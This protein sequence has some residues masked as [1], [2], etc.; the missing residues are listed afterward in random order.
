MEV[1]SSYS[2]RGDGPDNEDAY[3]YRDNIFW[4][5]DGATDLYHLNLFGCDD[6]VARYVRQ[7]N[8]CIYDNANGKDRL[9]DIL[10]KSVSD[11][12]KLL[13]LKT[14]DYEIYKLPSF[15]VL[16]ARM[17]GSKCEYYILGDCVLLV[18]NKGEIIKLTD[19]RLLVFTEKNRSGIEALKKSGKLTYENK[20]ELLRDTRKYMNTENGYWIGSVDCAGIDNAIQGEIDIDPET[21]CLGC[22]DGLMEA[23]DLFGISAIDGSIFDAEKLKHIVNA[24]RKCQQDDARNSVARVRKKDDLTYILVRCAYGSI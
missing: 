12:N 19:S 1:L 23:F 13:S 14:E 6:D 18:R 17:T 5:I 21:M 20:I 16:L 15:A 24:L 8:Q 4:V 9:A 11:T 3:G 2:E 10:R 7:L 22:S